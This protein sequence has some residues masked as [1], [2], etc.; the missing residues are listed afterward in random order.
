MIRSVFSVLVLALPCVLAAGEASSSDPPHVFDVPALQARHVKSLRMVRALLQRGAYAEAEKGLRE[1][2][3]RVPH[4]VSSHYNLARVLAL[5]N[6]NE[7][8]LD[9]LEKAVEFGFRDA[10][11][12][13]SDQSLRALR[14]TDRF[15]DILEL[16]NRPL[17][18]KS[19]GWQYQV[20]P[21][22]SADGKVLVAARNTA[23][24]SGSGVFHAF[25][26]LDPSRSQQPISTKEGMVGDLLRVWD[27]EETA[28]GNH[29]DLYDNHDGGH[30]NMNY[31]ALPRLTRVEF[32]QEARQRKLHMG[33]QL[34]FLYC[35]PNQ[36]SS[37]YYVTIGNS[38]TAVTSGAFWR[39]Q[40]RYALTQ[41]RG[42][43]ILYRQY[44]SNH[45]YFYPEHQ[46]HDPPG[47]GKGHG[48]VFPA[49]TPYVIISQGSS[50]SDRPFMD[51]VGATLAAFRPGVK[52]K[53][54]ISRTL[55]PAVQMIFR[56]SNKML[57]TPADYLTGRAHPT[58]FEGEQVNEEKMVRMAHRMTLDSLPPMLQLNVVEEDEAVVGRDYFDVTS[59][60]RLFNTPCAIA[61]VVKS[62]RYTRRMVVS[63]EESKDL[64]GKP[65][66]Y[67]WVLL[68]GDPERVRINKLNDSGSKAELLVSYHPRRPIAPGAKM[69]SNRV[70]IGCF[71][72]NGQYYSA[73]GFICFHYL[74]NE[75]RVYDDKNRILV[76]DYTDPEYKDNYVDPLLDY[77]KDWRDEY[78]YDEQG[79]R[80]GWTRIRDDQEQEFTADGRLILEKNAA[81]EPTK[82]TPVRY[83]AEQSS[84]REAARLKQVVVEDSR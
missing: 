50:G 75:K 84:E 38:S 29:G 14:Q 48:D 41:P 81:G 70:D 72:H 63:A 73:P 20:K 22:T 6:R 11:H 42:P 28:A 65:L 40:P 66:T 7:E 39:S 17:D 19:T 46:D 5:Q 56:N 27:M 49:N 30:S 59:R 82:T 16:A 35:R 25:F 52:K 54:R 23:W 80:S 53:L 58:V 51:A 67:R 45:L 62:T 57:E 13:R 2:V 61:R 34:S 60:E 44:V 4:D 68:R 9:A 36:E 32:S 37:P 64:D 71:V 55:I 10:E 8:A 43:G 69:E 21:V 15:S 24:Q 78:H 74:N 18:D 77:R 83:V 1:A 76:V 26:K 31:Q 12:I 3:E 79:N 47:E 33:V